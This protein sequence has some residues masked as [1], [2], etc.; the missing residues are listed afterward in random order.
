LRYKHTP[1]NSAAILPKLLG[2]GK[3]LNFAGRQT[4]LSIAVQ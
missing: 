2:H 3:F 4:A 1:F